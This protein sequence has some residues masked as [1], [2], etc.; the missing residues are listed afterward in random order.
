LLT[1][2]IKNQKG[3]SLISIVVAAALLGGLSMVMMQMGKQ[4]TKSVAKMNFDTE[5]SQITNEINAILSDPTSCKNTLTQASPPIFIIKY[6]PNNP[7]P[8][9]KYDIGQGPYGNGS[10]QIDSYVL[11]LSGTS[12]DIP[13]LQINFKNKA[14]LTNQSGSN[15][16]VSKIIKL[17]VTPIGTTLFSSILSCRSISTAI[18]TMWHRQQGADNNIYYNSGNVGIGTVTPRGGSSSSAVLDLGAP[19]TMSF[20]SMG[21]E[22]SYIGF[23]TYFNG[24]WKYKGNGMASILRQ[25]TTGLQIWSSPN[26]VAG[27]DIVQAPILA[28]TVA[29]NGNVGIGTAAPTATLHVNSSSNL[30]S[31]SVYISGSRPAGGNDSGQIRF[32]DNQNGKGWLFTNGIPGVSNNHFGI[33]QSNGTSGPYSYPMTILENGNVGIGTINPTAK[34]EVNGDVKIG[35]TNPTA[36][37]CTASQGGSTR[38]NNSSKTMEYCNESSWLPMGG[39]LSGSWHNMTASR[40]FN[41]AYTNSTGKTII[42]GASSAG[43][44]NVYP[45]ISAYVNGLWVGGSTTGPYSGATPHAAVSG[46]VVRTGASYSINCNI[47]M[48]AWSEFY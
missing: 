13:N 38:Y 46:V 10:V 2:S 4:S 1:S 18:D 25:D 30:I 12:P 3:F 8:V 20:V 45:E 35:N 41:T 5:V 47:G 36:T 19:G 31:S 34:L 6:I 44:A 28:M 37:I 26:N 21:N 43:A 48:T 7:T 17:D 23:N 33:I 16:L 29:P 14:I 27:E 39:G 32:N 22:G 11:N 42:N 40:S 9:H 24:S 15:A